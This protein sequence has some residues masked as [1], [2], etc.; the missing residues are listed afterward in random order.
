MSGQ[1]ATKVL[2]VED[3]PSDAV[4][5]TDNIL[6]DGNGGFVVKTAGTLK[7]GISLSG[8]YDAVLLDMWLP[9]SSGIET[10]L[11]FR[12]SAPAVPVIIITGLDNSEVSIKALQ[13]GAQDY[14]VK[15]R[16]DG[17]MVIRAIMYAIERKAIT[18]SLED[19]RMDLARVI[20]GAPI[21]MFVAGRDMRIKKCNETAAEFT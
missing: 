12:E 11:K 8:G 4:L 2:L 17:K 20:D 5:I 15:D 14:I 19:Y 16:L 9:D 18:D 21:M 6:L 3:N 7:E 10:L 1:A 13:S